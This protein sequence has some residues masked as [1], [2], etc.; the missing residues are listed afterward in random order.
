MT[1]DMWSADGVVVRFG[2][3]LALVVALVALTGCGQQS[4]G[5]P[6]SPTSTPDAVAYSDPAALFA[7]IEK[8]GAPKV[9][10]LAV[11]TFHSPS[12]PDAANAMRGNFMVAISSDRYQLALSNGAWAALLTM[13]VFPDGTARKLGAA[14]GQHI[15]SALGWPSIW[16]LQGPNWLVW[17]VDEQDLRGIQGAIGGTLGRTPVVT[18]SPGSSA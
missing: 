17:G 18:A 11:G 6:P 3:V 7:A 2:A 10:Q 9:E 1:F 4:T 5:S 14:Y 12:M 8:A 13:A 15:A 16:Q